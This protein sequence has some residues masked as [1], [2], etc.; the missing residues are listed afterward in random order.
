MSPTKLI[1]A[2][3][4]IA[5]A[6]IGSIGMASA[7]AAKLVGHDV[8]TS[9]YQYPVANYI[10]ASEYIASATGTV[11]TIELQS[12]G[13][14][15]AM[16][17][18][19]ADNGG[20]PGTLL[21]QS[22]G[23]SITTGLNN[24]PI[25]SISV[26][27]NMPYWLA[28]VSDTV[29]IL[30]FKI[31]TNIGGSY[32]TLTY[33]TN[34]PNPAGSGWTMFAGLNLLISGWNFGN[35]APLPP[36]TPTTPT[37]ATSGYVG[38]SYQYSSSATDPASKQVRLTFDWGDGTTTNTSFG[39][40]GNTLSAVHSYSNT[41]TYHIKALATN[42]VSLESG[43]SNSLSVLLQNSSPP[44]SGGNKTLAAYVLAPLT[45]TNSD[46]IE[47]L[48]NNS[49]KDG[50]ISHVDVADAITKKHIA[51]ILGTRT[52]VETGS[53]TGKYLAFNGSKLTY[54]SPSVSSSSG[55]YVVTVG[56]Y[57]N[58]TYQTTGTNDEIIVN[59]AWNAMGSDGVLDYVG[60]L[61]LGGS[62]HL[63][64]TKYPHGSRA[65][66]P[67]YWQAHSKTFESTNNAKITASTGSPMI[68]VDGPGINLKGIHLDGNRID[69]YEGSIYS[70]G[71]YGIDIVDGVNLGLE[72]VLVEHTGDAGIYIASGSG[73]TGYKQ[74]TNV[75][76]WQCYSGFVSR[77]S[78]DTIISGMTVANPRTYC[79][80]FEGGA[81]YTK[82]N[83]CHF[84]QGGNGLGLESER[85]SYF[86]ACN[87]QVLL[88]GYGYNQ[89]TNCEFDTYNWYAV[90][91]YVD[92]T[93][94]WS[95]HNGGD[96]QFTN[97]EFNG[98]YET[99][100]YTGGSLDTFTSENSITGCKFRDFASM[101]YHH[102]VME[103]GSNYNTI[104]GN[105]LV[106][107]YSGHGDACIVNHGGGSNIAGDA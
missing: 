38:T 9:D 71:A 19:Y 44:P 6:M 80:D 3:L 34:F 72:N 89:F 95:G 7:T 59:Q 22:D 31:E 21:G 36:N 85:V 27:A 90:Y 50:G 63:T 76:L 66:D 98:G 13:S 30:D 82:F 101:M 57:A 55:S 65:D 77:G 64:T 74:W 62:I 24:I 1:M 51:S 100:Q 35:V 16:V 18:V 88:G 87:C 41:G 12:A 33:G 5:I 105:T 48:T 84:W 96:N 103:S 2:L 61:M 11:D 26:T 102:L 107:A 67:N 56:P 29:N 42:N 52:V 40:S 10:M 78:G 83:N 46:V 86:Y 8:V 23:V 106:S 20:S 17:G 92:N 4:L 43:W 73:A 58:C 104:T 14:G 37:G 32:H 49:S 54:V 81:G 99:N 47:F 69:Q 45:A 70:S 94:G 79:I 15:H 39:A 25:S 93:G 91:N 97:C 28:A 60:G 75:Y 68:I 53:D